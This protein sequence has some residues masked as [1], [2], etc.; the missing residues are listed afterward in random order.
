MTYFLTYMTV[1]VLWHIQQLLLD[2]HTKNN[3]HA[4]VPSNW[5]VLAFVR[6]IVAGL[7]KKLN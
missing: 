1:H 6:F 2:F 7:Y 5:R 4:V 3:I